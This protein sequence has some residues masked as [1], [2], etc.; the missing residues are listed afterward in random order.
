MRLFVYKR[1][2]CNLDHPVSIWDTAN[3]LYTLNTRQAWHQFVISSSLHCLEFWQAYPRKLT[4]AQSGGKDCWGCAGVK[5]GRHVPSPIAWRTYD[6]RGF[7]E[8]YSFSRPFIPH[9]IPLRLMMVTQKAEE[10]KILF[11]IIFAVFCN[12]WL[13]YKVLCKICIFMLPHLTLYKVFCLFR[14]SLFLLASTEFCLLEA[15]CLE[16]SKF[17]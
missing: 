8:T 14:K 5:L 13:K 16:K 10:A 1:K 2:C 9:D 6:C 4:G 12:V 3:T 17:R 7:G 15:A 11:L